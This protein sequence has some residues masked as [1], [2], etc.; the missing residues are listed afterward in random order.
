MVMN[1]NS[2]LI[3]N[4]G[5]EKTYCISGSDVSIKYRHGNVIIK[6]PDKMSFALVFKVVQ[7]YY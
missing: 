7:R 5:D 3:L 1:S 6:N 2:I 4:P